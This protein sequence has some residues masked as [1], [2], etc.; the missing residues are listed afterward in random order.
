[1]VNQRHQAT[2]TRQGR[3]IFLAFVVFCLVSGLMLFA[4]TAHAESILRDT[5][6]EIFLKQQTLPIFTAAGIAPDNIHFVLIDENVVNAFVADGQNI[7]IYSGLILRTENLAEL[8]G[9]IAHETGH[10]VGGHLIKMGDVVESASRESILFT[11]LGIAAAAVSGNSN[12]GAAGALATQQTM[13]GKILAH[14][15]ANEASAD[16]AGVRFL[17]KAGLPA[18]GMASFM[19]KLMDQ[20]LL[21]E[22]RQIE[23]ARTHPLTRDRFEAIKDLIANDKPNPL[24]QDAENEYQRI[25]AKL[26]GY[27]LPRVVEREPVTADV[28]NRYA[29]AMAAYRL[30]DMPGALKLLD[31]LQKQEPSN[32]YFDELRGQILFE[33][34]KISDAVAAYK[35]TATEL[36]DAPLILQSYGQAL[37]ANNDTVAAIPVLLRAL[38]NE[39][40]SPGT[41][42]LLATAYGRSGDE[43]KAQLELAEESLLALEYKSAQHHAKAA[44]LPAGS[45]GAIRAADI[46]ALTKDKLDKDK[47]DDNTPPRH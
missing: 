17:H 12:I 26:R 15:R 19:A 13:L 43:G 23:Y 35:K 42:R 14:S 21:P 45:P 6:T 39:S 4:S 20:E 9:V 32:P 31:G 44:K 10:I 29:H 22:S 11:L 40:D 8:L 7:F 46:L 16:E 24:P 2:G 25:K 30:D 5:E 28:A 37:L 1:M 3:C 41:H 34:G 27:I 33:H 47:K 36:P 18:T 38:Q